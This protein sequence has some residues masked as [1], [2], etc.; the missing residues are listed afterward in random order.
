MLQPPG[1]VKMSCIIE[2]HTDWPEALL[3]NIRTGIYVVIDESQRAG[4][5]LIASERC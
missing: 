2:P 4:F 3:T 5:E 1:V